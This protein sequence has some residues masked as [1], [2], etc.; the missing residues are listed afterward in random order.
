[1]GIA[2]G[3]GCCDWRLRTF[4]TAYL[5]FKVQRSE[6]DRLECP[7]LMY[8]A[9]NDPHVPTQTVSAFQVRL[10]GPGSA[11]CTSIPALS[12]AFNRQGYPLYNEAA[13]AQLRRRTLAHFQHLLP[14][15]RGARL[16]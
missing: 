7:L 11:V 2:A 10:G 12:T 8:F 15:D 3:P 9:E 13:A 4:G 6:A 14:G 16:A 1:V 5:N